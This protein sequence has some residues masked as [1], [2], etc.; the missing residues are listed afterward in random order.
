MACNPVAVSVGF[1][2]TSVTGG[3]LRSSWMVLFDT[4]HGAPVMSRKVFDWNVCCILVLD[5]FV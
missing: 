3:M 5:G 4:Y 1:L 2:I